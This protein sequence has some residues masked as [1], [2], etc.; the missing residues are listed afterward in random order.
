MNYANG[1]VY[2]GEWFYNFRHG[3]GIM[4]WANGAVYDGEWSNDERHG[5]GT[6]GN[7][8]G[9]FFVVRWK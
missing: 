8:H 1:D 2:E 6:H 3:K 9:D 5:R 4:R 7:E